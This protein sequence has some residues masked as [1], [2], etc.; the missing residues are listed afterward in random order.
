[1]SSF[2][3]VGLPAKHT[4]GKLTATPLPKCTRP[5]HQYSGLAVPLSSRWLQVIQTTPTD[6]KHLELLRCFARLFCPRRP[7]ILGKKG[8][9]ETL[10]NF[11]GTHEDDSEKLKL[12]GML[13]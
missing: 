10:Q 7:D 11:F 9:L 2:T 5:N 1:M 8:D 12:C 3:W 4:A 13:C 6:I